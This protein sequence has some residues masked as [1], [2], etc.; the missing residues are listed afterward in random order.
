MKLKELLIVV[1]L[2]AGLGICAAEQAFDSQP[3]FS[4]P[5]KIEIKTADIVQSTSIKFPAVNKKEG[6]KVCLFFRASLS[7]PEPGGW[8]NYLAIKLNNKVL[9]K[10]ISSGEPRILRRGE[11]LRTTLQSPHDSRDW[12]KDNVLLVMFGPGK[13]EVDKRIIAPREEGYDYWLD[14]SD[15]VN[16]VETGADDRIERADE[17]TLELT[18]AFISSLLSKVNKDAKDVNLN[19]G[20]LK[21][22]Y[23]PSE[24]VEKNRGGQVSL[25]KYNVSASAAILKN[26]NFEVNITSGGDMVV[27]IA[28]EN[29]YFASE[30]SFPCESKMKF[31][32][33]T[34]EKAVGNSFWKPEIKKINESTVQLE[35]S[36]G[37][38][39]L[40]RTIS[41]ENGRIH[42]SDTLT[43]KVKEDI[44][45]YF[46][47]LV[48]Y[49]ELL[50]NEK[51]YLGGQSVDKESGISAN[52]TVFI[53]GEKSSIGILAA[54]DIFRVQLD[55]SKTG[56]IITME[57][58]HL[59]L[60]P[61]E[62]YSVKRVIYP[63]ATT[64]Y[65]DFVNSVRRDLNLNFRIDGP[66]YFG[67]HI[68]VGMNVSIAV[69][70]PWFEYYDGLKLSRDEYKAMMQK[71]IN[72]LRQAHPEI[73]ILASMET[74][75]ITLDKNKIANGDKLPF[76]GKT[77]E[78][79]Y[80]YVLSKE[81]GEIIAKSEYS[82]Y[83]DSLLRTRE[84]QI[85]AD[86]YYPHEPYLQLLVQLE[87]GNYRY[88]N[89]LEQIDFLI[90][91][92]GF[93]GIYCDQFDGGG[94]E[95]LSSTG[96]CSFDS[97]DGH[98][99]DLDEKGNIARKYKDFAITGIS[100]RKDIIEHVLNQSK[101]FVAN[102]QPTSGITNQLHSFRF[103]EMENDSTIKNF[104]LSREKPPVLR[105]QAKS[106]L[107]GSPIILG[108]RPQNYTKD[109][110]E[111]ARIL[112]RG[113]ITALKHGLLYYYYGNK[114]KGAGGYGPVNHMFPFTPVELN[115]GFLIGKER[116]ITCV[117]G[118]YFWP[119]KKKPA[120]FLF[121]ETGLD[122]SNDFK[123]IEKNNGWEIEVKLND[124]NEIAVIEYTK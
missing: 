99:V 12:W 16:Y 51:F 87:K 66:F 98:T 72:S 76:T 109:Q 29:Y 19:V 69:L 81:Q 28:G 115:E 18:S 107:S 120:C 6:T 102:S 9:G 118:K 111:M 27:S 24:Q 73:K 4:A 59:G 116:I 30:F 101:T 114:G 95:Y 90:K 124:W 65:F 113:I 68:P 123:M 79:E 89:M 32:T 104:I 45:I 93:D 83:S 22:V 14:I 92:V 97:W 61:D 31:N 1:V 54:D 33:L 40:K 44:G 119:D 121:D 82:K 15:V 52:P 39:V 8:S 42:I 10:Y 100:A 20:G 106:Q 7:T 37:T 63:L 110:N 41:I 70:H 36:S 17:N 85:I 13:G 71:K 122:K 3:V 112:T 67:E 88:K 25:L 56:N 96:R 50:K 105:F 108:L 47:Y 84:G 103:H 86:T 60:R 80:G 77:G 74:N 57:D 34:P 64:K 5:E 75:L 21:V 58:K 78:G 26:P 11:F 91:D 48:S 55:M 35:S 117:S 53:A 46:R 94:G 49:P 43:N 2:G 38:Y 23:V 62:S